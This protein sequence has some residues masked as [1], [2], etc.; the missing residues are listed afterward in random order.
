MSNP[1]FGSLSPEILPV[2]KL[3]SYKM[4]DL[5]L[6]MR[7]CLSG[8]PEGRFRPLQLVG[9]FKGRW[10]RRLLD[11]HNFVL[12]LSDHFTEGKQL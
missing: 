11:T 5:S 4:V 1:R 12:I 10:L 7:G 2:V 9:V 8:T 6:F 3:I